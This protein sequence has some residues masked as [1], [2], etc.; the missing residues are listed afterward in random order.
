MFLQARG[1]LL[2]HL[3][4]NLFLN[5]FLLQSLLKPGLALLTHVVPRI[6]IMTR[7]HLPVQIIIDGQ[8]ALPILHLAL[9][10][11]CSGRLLIQFVHRLD[12]LS[13]P[14]FVLEQRAS[15]R[16]ILVEMLQVLLPHI[17]HICCDSM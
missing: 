2:G 5:R 6:L 4:L 13:S 16:M 11:G 14:G 8:L 7:L 15:K 3:G 17:L 12:V 1:L 9:Q 10:V